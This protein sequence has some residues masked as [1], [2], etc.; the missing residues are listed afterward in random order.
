MT[1][2]GPLVL[3][4]VVAVVTTV[5]VVLAGASLP[6]SDVSSSGGCDIPDRV[7]GISA[8][9]VSAPGGGGVRVVEQGF[10]QDPNSTVSLGAVL[11]NSGS[12][13]AYR[14]QV[15]F[16]LFDA[17][18]SE[19]PEAGP[20]KLT[21]EIP[22]ILPG[23]RIGAGAG[24]Y[25]ADVRVASVEI[26]VGA[27]TWVPRDAVGHSFSPVGATYLRTTRFNPRSPISVDVRYQETSAN[28]RSLANRGTAVVFRDPT[29]KVV[30][31]EVGSPD[32]PIMFRDE[33]GND[34]GGEKQRPPSPSCS[35]GER[36]TWIVP[37]RGEPVT[38]DDA[39]TAIYPY[40]DLSVP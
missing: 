26:V 13:V 31:G 33:Q 19:L 17:S 28:C 15:E 7:S 14:T 22:I 12:S 39:R 23:Q 21:V 3:V 24:T 10:T 16:R 18:H 27:T 1:K 4:A 35:Q 20:V 40:C 9:A 38:A 6:W 37:P 32:T 30:G 29:G 11:E 36:E 8:S 5:T 2:V 34:L 25:R